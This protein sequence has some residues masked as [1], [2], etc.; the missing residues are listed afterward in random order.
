M[1]K[2]I[3]LL[4][5]LLPALVSAQFNLYNDSPI[6]QAWKNVGSAEFSAGQSEELSFAFNPVSGEPYI[7][8]IDIPNNRR[9]SV[10]RFNNNQWVDVG[11]N[12][13]TDTVSFC[14]DIEFSPTGMPYI[15]F[16]AIAYRPIDHYPYGYSRVK[17]FDGSN[18]V[19]FG[20]QHFCPGQ[21]GETFPKIKFSPAGELYLAYQDSAIWQVRLMKFDGASWIHID[22]G[23]FWECPQYIN[24][25]F[26]PTNGQ[27]YI[28]YQ[29]DCYDSKATVITF[30]G[31]SWVHVGPMGFSSSYMAENSLAISPSGEPYLAF[32]DF[33]VYG[34]M[35][36]MKFNG[37][38]W[39]NVGIAG[40]SG[41]NSRYP[42]LGFN[43]SGE[44]VVAFSDEL[45]LYKARAM[46][47]NGSNWVDLG[48][49]GFSIGT[50][51]YESLAFSPNN[52]PYVAFSDCSNNCGAT[53]MKYDSVYV[54]ISEPKALTFSLYPNPA[55]NKIS[56]MTSSSPF[57][58]QL[59]ITNLNGQEV[60]TQQISDPKTVIDI[61][62]LSSGVYFVRLTNDKG[63]AV[64]KFV[65]Q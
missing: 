64:R 16:C 59:S 65:K 35:T 21:S 44:P 1:K 25:V 8:Y 7:A 29:M 9:V 62:T 24:L 48:A 15:A 58:S 18:W 43:N 60:I 56:L 23:S 40:F 33:N 53:V 4:L 63:V 54:G 22:T 39:V 19:D 61:S 6:N 55:T 5:V 26:S 30:N 52:E 13:V 45:N 2:L 50:A 20:N 31:S 11:S 34:S 37:T 46:R 38:N 41:L 12:G 27:P 32:P 10:M 14:P 28:S 3:C 36:V 42:S 51:K 17:K 47:F 49:A 57:I